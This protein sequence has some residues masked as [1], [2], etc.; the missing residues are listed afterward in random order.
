MSQQVHQAKARAVKAAG[1]VAGTAADPKAGLQ[2][3]KARSSPRR[4]LLVGAA[5]VAAYVVARRVTR[6]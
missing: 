4:L 3:A 6:R 1:A 2:R 5:I